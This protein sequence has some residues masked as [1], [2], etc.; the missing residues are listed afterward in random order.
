MLSLKI[1][2]PPPW[3]HITEIKSEEGEEET[4]N[5]SE[6]N[7]DLSDIQT[8]GEVDGLDEEGEESARRH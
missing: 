5:Q 7:N 3:P 8:P 6:E 2:P 4:I 1:P